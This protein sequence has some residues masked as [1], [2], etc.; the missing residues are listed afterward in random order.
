MQNVSMFVVL[1]LM[2]NLVDANGKG[3][4]KAVSVNVRA[5]AAGVMVW[6]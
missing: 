6:P 3:P 1:Q 5:V 4:R 2:R